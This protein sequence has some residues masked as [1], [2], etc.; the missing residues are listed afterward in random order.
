[1]KPKLTLGSHYGHIGDFDGDATSFPNEQ[2]LA[3][4]G[5]VDTKMEL[6][7]SKS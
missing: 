3:V 2:I 4:S 6:L 5:K 1:M 7:L